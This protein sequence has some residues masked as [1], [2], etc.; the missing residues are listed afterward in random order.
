VDERSLAD[1]IADHL[2]LKA[3]NSHLE[4]TMPLAD[5]LGPA[6]STGGGDGQSV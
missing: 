3:R 2:A 1:E 6:Y 4:R 5:Y